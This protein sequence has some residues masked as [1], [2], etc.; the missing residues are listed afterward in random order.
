MTR[1]WT[2]LG[3]F[4]AF[5]FFASLSTLAQDHPTPGAD[6]RVQRL[7]EFLTGVKLTGHFTVK[8][9][10]LDRLTPEEYVILQAEKGSEG[11]FWIITARIK[12]GGKDFTLPMPLEIK[13]AGNTPV[14]TVDRLTLPGM[15]TFDARVIIRPDGYAGTWQHDDTGGHLFG[16][17]EKLTPDELAEMRK[18]V[19]QRDDKVP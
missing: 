18:P 12:Y 16:T 4:A 17:I 11:D 9:Q 3:I 1:T 5:V 8:G 7:A 10:P 19:R 2:S 15:G 14:I 13:W 6:E